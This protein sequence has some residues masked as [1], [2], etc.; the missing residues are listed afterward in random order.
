MKLT[1]WAMAGATVFV[2]Y[3]YSIGKKTRG[4]KVFTTQDDALEKTEPELR[5]RA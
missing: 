2:I 4:A 5:K 3:K 1:R